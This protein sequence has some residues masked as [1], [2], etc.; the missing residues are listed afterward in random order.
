MNRSKYASV[1]DAARDRKS[2]SQESVTPSTPVLE[3]TVS[4][5]ELMEKRRGRPK[6]KRS[7]PEFDQVTAYI[8]KDTYRNVKIAL[9]GLQEPQEFSELL[10]ELLHSW[11]S[12]QKSGL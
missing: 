11:V 12:R 1:M 7:D 10:E 9:L 4:P 8:R 3:A 2:E 6:G 5:S